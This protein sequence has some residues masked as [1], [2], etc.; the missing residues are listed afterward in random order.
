[1]VALILIGI[2]ITLGIPTFSTLMKSYRLNGA[3]RQ[4]IGDLMW[5]RMQ[6][7]NQ[8]NEFKI[9]FLSSNQYK[10]LDDDDNDGTADSGE[11]SVTKNIQDDYYDVTFSSTADPIFYPRGSAY[12]ATITLTNSYGSKTITISI[13]GRVKLS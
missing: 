6:A 13:T 2:L 4:L 12:G 8:N 9:F 5:A 11:W 10:I 3:A 1:M 7:V